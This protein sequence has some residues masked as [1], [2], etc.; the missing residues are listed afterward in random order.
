V[1]ELAPADE[2]EPEAQVE[3]E[4]APEAEYWLA[5]HCVQVVAEPTSAY[6]AEQVVQAVAPALQVVQPPLLAVQ[7]WALILTSNIAKSKI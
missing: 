3:Q 2:N 7:V 6:P 4:V 1:Q 5:V